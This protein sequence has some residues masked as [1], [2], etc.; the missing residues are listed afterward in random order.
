MHVT[1]GNGEDKLTI[2]LP[3]YVVVD[4]FQHK[5]LKPII[6]FD[7]FTRIVADIEDRL[8]DPADTDLIVVN[9]A[10]RCTPTATILK[11]LISLDKF[12]KRAKILIST[13]THAP[14]TREQLLYIFD[15]Q[16]DRL[17]PWIQAHDCRDKSGMDLVG[18]DSFDKPV[19]LNR[20]FLKAEKV[21]ILGS[22]EPHYFAGFTGG[23]KAI[24]P[25]LCDLETTIR[26]HRLAESFESQPL[27]L[28]GN[29]V[30]QHLQSL[31]DLLPDKDIAALMTVQVVTDRGN[32]YLAGGTL[33][34]AFDKAVRI[35]AGVFAPEYK[36][37]YGLLLAETLPPL[38]ANL[39][40]LQKSLENCQAAVKDDGT[41]ILFSACREGIGSESFYNL[42][43]NWRP[44]DTFESESNRNFGI[45]KLARVYEIGRRINIHLH[46]MLPVGIPE[47]VFFRSV[48][49]P[50]ALIDR[51]IKDKHID[52][53]A[54][55]HDAGHTVLT[56]NHGLN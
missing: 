25:G 24:F 26:N 18:H 22:V 20:T 44:A 50:Q 3:D 48:E 37:R 23:R 13:G 9:D 39:Y 56:N 17:R 8:F 29:P 36:S 38:N 54:L 21:L 27:R 49:D 32:F 16:Y 34:E 7:G 43:D 52:R 35:A 28:H 19:Y 45:H 31:M 51:T 47:K 41:I 33:S 6:D 40:Q 15:D 10:Y 11:W 5:T 30:E 4:E 12:N 1:L 53:L 42:A 2:K 46:S 55:V 14:P